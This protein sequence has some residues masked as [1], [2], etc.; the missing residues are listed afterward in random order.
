VRR[1]TLAAWAVVLLWGFH[2]VVLYRPLRI[3]DPERYLY[4]RFGWAAGG[5]LLFSLFFP[6]FRNISR[7]TWGR[8]FLLSMIGIVGYQWVFLRAASLL[9]P[10]PLV[11]ILSLGPVI[12][13]LYSHFRGHES[14]SPLQWAAMGVVMAGIFMVVRG[15]PSG[16]GPVDR[17]TGLFMAFFSLVFFTVATFLTKSLLTRVSTVQATFI[18]VLIGGLVLIPFHPAWIFLPAGNR[19]GVILL[20]LLYSTFVALFLAYFNWNVAVSCIGPSRAGLWTN[21]QPLVTAAGS[22]LFLGHHLSWGQV[23]GGGLA[24]G[25]Y[26]VFFGKRTWGW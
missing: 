4:L 5:V 1:G 6:L 24:I 8:L 20:S 7:E 23:L 13:A 17:S 12:V 25:G 9:D 19:N 2:Y 26:W 11:L 16:K 14:F 21:A 18:P 22:F 15:E 3:I 10:V